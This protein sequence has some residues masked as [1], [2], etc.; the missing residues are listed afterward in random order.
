MAGEHVMV[1]ESP[2]TS[3]SCMSRAERAL[4]HGRVPNRRRRMLVV[5]SPAWTCAAMLLPVGCVGCVQCLR[6][7]L[8]TSFLAALR[9]ACEKQQ[10]HQTTACVVTFFAPP[11]TYFIAIIA[12]TSCCRPAFS[13]SSPPRSSCSDVLPLFLRPVAGTENV[14]ACRLHSAL[15]DARRS[16]SHPP[17]AS[18]ERSAV[19]EGAI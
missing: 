15:L 8:A 4:Q 10:E 2:S 1:L 3:Q 12:T 17:G 19:G 7:P 13:S 11:L 9:M 14:K 5:K 18:C 16:P 6:R